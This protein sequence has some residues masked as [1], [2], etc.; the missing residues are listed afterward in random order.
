MLKGKHNILQSVGS[1]RVV[2]GLFA[3][4]CF[5]ELSDAISLFGVSLRHALYFLFLVILFYFCAVLARRRCVLSGEWPAPSLAGFIF[6]FLLVYMFSITGA[7]LVLGDVESYFVYRYVV[8]RIISTLFF[9]F[10]F[11]LFFLFGAG[12]PVERARSALLFAAWVGLFFALIAIVDYVLVGFGFEYSFRNAVGTN[13]SHITERFEYYRFHRALGVNREPSLLAANL[14][15]ILFVAMNLGRYF[16]AVIV[17]CAIFLALSII[18]FFVIFFTIFLAWS[19]R[20]VAMTNRNLLLS[21]L[22]IGLGFVLG[23]FLAFTYDG[24]ELSYLGYRWAL[25]TGAIAEGPG[26]GSHGVLVAC[27]NNVLVDLGLDWVCLVPGRG[28]VVRYLADSLD[29]GWGLGLGFANLDLGGF[30]GIDAPASFLSTVAA[31]FAIGGWFGAIILFF[32]FVIFVVSIVA[33]FYRVD[34]RGL[35]QLSGYFMVVVCSLSLLVF[36]LEQ[37]NAIISS[38]LGFSLGALRAHDQFSGFKLRLGGGNARI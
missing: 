22:S 20:P 33:R 38:L 18:A 10:V 8:E 9:C 23:D 27:S 12:F 35:V 19:L 15:P 30:F 26:D 6:I 28:D 14:L 7:E 32:W 1:V 31:V 16:I 2:G 24:S 25:V 13:Y 29:V 5:A 3:L 17:S 21:V 4:L 11:F 34:S 37:P 36:L